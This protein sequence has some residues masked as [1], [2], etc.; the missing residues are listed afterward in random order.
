MAVAAIALAVFAFWAWRPDVGAGAQ[1]D[2]PSGAQRIAGG[3][4]G[5]LP[6]ASAADEKLD[7]RALA[8]VVALADAE[9]AQLLLIARHGHLVIEHYAPGVNADSLVNGGA[10]TSAV[11]ALADGARDKLSA[12]LWQPLNAHEARLS[13]CC[14]YA[15]AADWLRVGILL[16]ADGRFEG[17]DVVPGTAVAQLQ[18]AGSSL[19]AGARASGAEAFVGRDVYFLRG[20]DRTRVW[21]SPAAQ[22]VAL[23]VAG[24]ARA[25]GWDETQLFNLIL[26]SAADRVASNAETSLLNQLVPGH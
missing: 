13:E 11:L 25:N 3:D 18:N 21:I 5:G 16:A 20:S 12:N 24:P 23:H 10:M 8:N 9:G 14:L 6:R 1:T 22:I 19:E 4:G 7:Q 15:R 2:V 17:A 26:R